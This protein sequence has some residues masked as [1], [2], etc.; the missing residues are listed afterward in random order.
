[1]LLTL[2]LRQVRIVST[3]LLGG[4]D[5]VDTSYTFSGLP[6]RV[7]KTH[8]SV[9]DSTLSESYLYS[10][11]RWGR[12]LKTEHQ[13]DGHSETLFTQ[14]YDAVERLQ[15]KSLGSL[16]EC[17]TYQYNVRGWLSGIRS[18]K[19]T[20]TLYYADEGS[21]NPAYNGNI[22]SMTWRNGDGSDPQSYAFFYDGMNRLWLAEYTDGPTLSSHPNRYTEQVTRYDKQG[23][24]LGLKRYGR[25]SDGDYGLI[26]DLSMTYDGNRLQSVADCADASAYGDGF[27]FK[28]GADLTV[29]YRYD[30][31][32]NLTQD[33]NRKA[34]GNPI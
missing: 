29:E 1:M 10:Y 31:N 24:I 11:D 5:T 17:L 33:L 15:T 25:V 7:D 23:N 8:T 20:Q 32:G 16:G 9:P 3:N 34:I 12:L 30:A 27:E 28:D 14:T 13:L 19:F 18:D 2:H 26:D 4:H 22:C 6:K 21:G